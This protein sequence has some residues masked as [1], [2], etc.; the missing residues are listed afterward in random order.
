[1]PMHTETL[2]TAWYEFT[3]L[4]DDTFVMAVLAGDDCE[5][6]TAAE[7][8]DANATAW[9]ISAG[10]NRL[11]IS[12][13]N[14][15]WIRCPSG[16]CD[17]TYSQFGGIVFDTTKS[18]HAWSDGVSVSGAAPSA[19]VVVGFD[20]TGA[21]EYK[22]LGFLETIA[23]GLASAATIDSARV[24]L[25]LEL[26]SA[27]KVFRIYGIT[28]P[29]SVSHMITDFATLESG[30]ALST[31]YAEFT[32][33]QTGFASVDITDVVQE[34]V[35]VAGWDTDSPIQLW[36]GPADTATADANTTISVI[37]SS[38]S[39]VFVTAS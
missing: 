9:T 19:L 28:D 36:I 30:F 16:T 8:P 3:D 10:I 26:S 5:V 33:G 27:G 22:W 38:P 12:E 23:A 25:K 13:G 11:D 34:L 32:I 21:E 17:L 29:D 31:E 7:E 4:D 14:S 39:A 24:L 37:V 15:L 20:D 35:N 1:M 2:T 18:K 6:I